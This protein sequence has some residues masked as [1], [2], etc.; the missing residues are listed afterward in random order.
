M[1]RHSLGPAADVAE[2]TA[3]TAPDPTPGRLAV[4]GPSPETEAERR[5]GLRK[6]KT[7]ATGLLLLATVVYLL[8]RWLEAQPGE[9]ATW[10]GFVRAGAE[11]GMIG[12]LADWFAVTALFRHPLHL[13][14]PHTA[15]V[16]NKKDQ[17][18]ESLAGFVGDN[19]LN[20]ELIT[21]KVSQARIPERIGEWL[22][23]EGNAERTSAEAGRLLAAIVRELDPAEAEAIIQRGLI[24][25]L[26]EP[27][28]GPPAGRILEGLIEEGKTEPV[29]DAIAAWADEKARASEDLIDR[30]LGERAPS[31][32]PRFVNDLVSDK[33]YRE[34]TAW[35]AAVAR[36]KNHEARR[37]MRRVVA[38]LAHD[39]QHDPETIA[40]L[41]S[42]KT[43]VLG[44]SAIQGAPAA[45]WRGASS[46]I[47]EAA[48]DPTSVLRTKITAFA[49]DWGHRICEDEQMRV[50]LERRII[51]G[52]AFL[53]NNYADEITAIISETIERWDAEEASDKIELMVGKDLQFIRLNGT[54]VGA[55]AGLII[56]ALSHLLFGAL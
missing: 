15:I 34:L 14:I 50:S 51:D 11:A 20:A 37:E 29:V 28:W 17:I 35:T 48:E 6:Y 44:S 49:R 31:W 38:R 55:L 56:Y 52:A 30:L 41:E 42:W 21:E 25:R 46:S 33:V 23:A 24:D 40:K 27:E 43:D 47:V 12:G 7:I 4:P 5:R 53:A 32:A 39:L 54:I 2:A 3:P 9:T 10:V 1:G 26:A 45:I 18:G 8:C 19:F 22:V 16:R 13:P 36:D